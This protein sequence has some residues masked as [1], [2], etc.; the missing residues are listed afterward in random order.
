[1]IGIVKPAILLPFSLTTGLAPA[2]LEPLLAHELAHI[3]RFDL[4]VNLLEWAFNLDP[5]FADRRFMD[6][7][8]FAG[9]PAVTTLFDGNMRRYRI[10]FVR[11]KD[12][13]TGEEAFA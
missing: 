11:I 1:M 6:P 10:E 4:L 5:F 12:T 13:V 2:Q 3:R 9:L 8:G 7:G